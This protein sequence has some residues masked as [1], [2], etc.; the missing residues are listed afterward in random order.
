[1]LHTYV[2]SYDVADDRRRARIYGYL[3]GWGDHLQFSVFRVMLS[4][5]QLATFTATLHEF[6]H[7]EFDQVLIF[8]LGPTSGRAKNCVVSIGMSYTHPE[9]HAVVV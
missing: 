3:R 6:V 1:M 8:D 9:R 2:V 5:T 4:P 7:H